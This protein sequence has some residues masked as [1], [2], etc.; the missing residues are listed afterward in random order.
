MASS[1]A[2]KGIVP[3][4]EVSDEP[5]GAR[6]L[7]GR[8][9][10]IIAQ[11]QAENLLARTGPLDDAILR[12]IEE[13]R[14]D[15]LQ[16]GEPL[17]L[18]D[19]PDAIMALSA[20]WTQKMRD[21]FGSLADREVPQVILPA[22]EIDRAIPIFEVMNRGGTP[23]TT[24]DLVVAKMARRS[25]ESLADQLREHALDFSLDVKSSVWGANDALYPT[26]W[27]ASDYNFVIERD[28]LSNHFKTSLLSL[29]SAKSQSDTA[30]VEAI[31]VEHLKRAAILDLDA[32]TIEM[33]W[34][35]N[36][37]AVMRAWAFLNLRCGIRNSADLRNKLLVLPLAFVVADDHVWNDGTSLDR[38]EYWYWCSVLGGTYTERQIDNC[39]NDIRLLDGWLNRDSVNPFSSRKD[40]VL[41]APGYSDR[42]SML[43]TGEES[44]VASD[45]GN[46]LAQYV[47]SRNP[48]DFVKSL[49]LMAWASDVTLELHHVIPLQEATSIGHSTNELRSQAGRRH[50]L[51][52]PLNR[53]FLSKGSNQELGARSIRQY[54]QEVSPS[55]LASHFF[56][57]DHQ[58]YSRNA[59]EEPDYYYNRL[60]G[61]RYEALLQAVHEELSRLEH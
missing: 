10:Q 6:S 26:R 48:I 13:E 22:N 19:I 33:L 44:G 25:D 21:Y 3:L 59:S 53:S 54:T 52:S 51:N 47:L 45:V 34:Q 8:T 31:E 61:L 14:P 57:A 38:L 32:K 18:E 4:W 7:H 30:S 9:I 29:L 41:N 15:L 36:A 40:L 49:R 50:K 39:V 37:T 58:V 46:Y 1:F 11:R 17:K 16:V 60:L 24:F 27:D 28:T 43:R 56:P 20:A 23:L 35:A 12:A 55:I 2:E 42:G 5:F